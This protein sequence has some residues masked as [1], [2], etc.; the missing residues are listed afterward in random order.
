MK[1][2]VYASSHIETNSHLIYNYR[3]TNIHTIFED[4]G[5]SV[6]W[7]KVEVIL[8]VSSLTIVLKCHYMF[9]DILLFCL[10]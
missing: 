7:P 2:N 6:S 10:R 9:H 8:I 5:Y 1:A 4:I 3:K